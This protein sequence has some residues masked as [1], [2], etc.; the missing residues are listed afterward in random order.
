M[1]LTWNRHN[2]RN[3]S[4]SSESWKTV[5]LWPEKSNMRT[6]KRLKCHSFLSTAQFPWPRF[7]PAMAKI[8]YKKRLSQRQPSVSL[9]FVTTVV[10]NRSY[11]FFGESIMFRLEFTIGLMCGLALVTVSG[12]P[13]HYFWPD[14]YQTHFIYPSPMYIN[15][16][17]DYRNVPTYP[18]EL[19]PNY[20]DSRIFF[21]LLTGNKG[22]ITLTYSTSTTTSTS[23]VTTFCTT[24]TATLSTCTVGRRRRGLFYNDFQNNRVRHE[25]PYVEDDTF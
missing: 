8:P 22:L 7:T 15:Q 21:G 19:Q 23:T 3:A 6:F 25:L 17:V 12:E 10:I 24:S 14:G 13:Q 20:L 4:R 2:T 16:P 1:P 11:F 18:L 5:I 9:P